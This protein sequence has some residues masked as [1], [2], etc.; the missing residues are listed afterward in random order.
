M[1]QIDRLQTNILAERP[2]GCGNHSTKR[3]R[4]AS[5]RGLAFKALPLNKIYVLGIRVEI[6]YGDL[7]IDN[8]S[9]R[10]GQPYYEIGTLFLN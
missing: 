6:E 3:G 4:G 8:F 7:H 9:R 1:T 2:R 5:R 10:F